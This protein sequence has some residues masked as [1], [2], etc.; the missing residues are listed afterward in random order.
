MKYNVDTL[1]E[2]LGRFLDGDD[3]AISVYKYRTSYKVDLVP[4]FDPPLYSQIC[5]LVHFE[6]EEVVTI[7]KSVLSL[8]EKPW[9]NERK[10]YVY[11]SKF[12]YDKVF[13][14]TC[15][16][17]RING[18]TDKDRLACLT[19]VE[20]AKKWKY[21]KYYSVR[22]NNAN[23][24]VEVASIVAED[25]WNEYTKE[26]MSQR[27]FD[28][29][30]LDSPKP[31]RLKFKYCKKTV[32]RI[33]SEFETRY[34]KEFS[35]LEVRKWLDGRMIDIVVRHYIKKYPDS[36]KEDIRNHILN[37]VGIKVSE[38]SIQKKNEKRF[39]H[40]KSDEQSTK[41]NERALYIQELIKKYGK[42]WRQFADAKDIQWY[43]RHR[44]LF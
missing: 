1:T 23:D 43:K 20:I 5:H 29:T 32:E 44:E 41:E 42:Q 39:N 7:N 25:V 40:K 11:F 4:K 15:R 18:I 24:I 12:D 10:D 14:N 34:D 2:R 35:G 22:L 28:A 31:N 38:K 13:V 3:S 27:Y 21:T 36:T 9:S 19:A 16:L 8:L 6:D 33:K 26:V 37:E 17:Q 30:T